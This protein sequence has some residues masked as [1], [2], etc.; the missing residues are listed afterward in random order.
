MRLFKVRNFVRVVGECTNRAGM[1]TD[2]GDGAACRTHAHTRF[3]KSNEA[4]RICAPISPPRP[5]SKLILV[6]LET[7]QAIL[8]DLRRRVRR[9]VPKRQ[10]A[11]EP[12]LNG[13]SYPPPLANNAWELEETSPRRWE[14][15]GNSDGEEPEAAPGP[16]RG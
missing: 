1:E 6:V 12:E 14:L 16:S 2:L 5:N 7:H 11:Q 15:G 9:R 8:V 13:A 3:E 10:R 4:R